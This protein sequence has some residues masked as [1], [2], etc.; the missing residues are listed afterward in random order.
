MKWRHTK[1]GENNNSSIADPDSTQKE[2]PT[3]IVQNATTT[4]IVE[5]KT[6]LSEDEEDIE[7]QVDV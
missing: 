6:T 7:I 1:Q 2:I 4:K 3:K 5:G